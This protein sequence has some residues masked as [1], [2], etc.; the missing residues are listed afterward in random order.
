MCCLS[1]QSLADDS[2][3]DLVM[4]NILAMSI[5]AT[6][7]RIPNVRFT[8]AQVLAKLSQ[9]VDDATVQTQIR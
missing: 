3:P 8:A 4:T 1:H 2:I 9:H 7:D 6:R 5:N